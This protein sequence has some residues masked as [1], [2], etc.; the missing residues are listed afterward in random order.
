[1]LW[2]LE[3]GVVIAAAPVRWS[4]HFTRAV[5]IL[6][7]FSTGFPGTVVRADWCVLVLSHVGF[8]LAL[9][10]LEGREYLG[11]PVMPVPKCLC[12]CSW[13]AMKFFHQMGRNSLIFELF[14][15]VL[16]CAGMK[17]DLKQEDL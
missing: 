2:R 5:R 13:C 6:A 8:P 10:M 16:F 12:P 7:A 3:L 1:M 9:N 15:P 17:I 14:I 11:R 4:S